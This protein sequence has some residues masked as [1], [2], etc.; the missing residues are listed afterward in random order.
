[1]GHVEIDIS[2]LRLYQNKPNLSLYSTYYAEECNELAVPISAYIIAPRQHS[3]LRRC[4]S[5]G[6]RFATLCKIWP[7]F[8]IRTRHERQPFGHRGVIKT[9]S[10]KFLQALSQCL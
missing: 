10:V 9:K 1:V 7:C 3:Y 6:E 5:G 4:W 8:G 2:I